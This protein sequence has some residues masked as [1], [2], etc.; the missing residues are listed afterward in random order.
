[1]LCWGVFC[2]LSTSNTDLRIMSLFRENKFY[3]KDVLTV[4]VITGCKL[5]NKFMWFLKISKNHVAN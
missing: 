5:K 3:K 1:M 2:K 4:M